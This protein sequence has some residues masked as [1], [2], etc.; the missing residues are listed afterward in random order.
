MFSTWRRG[1]AIGVLLAVVAACGGGDDDDEDVSFD[2]EES[3]TFERDDAD[4]TTTT[5]DPTE[6]ID[7]DDVA[8]DDV[9]DAVIFAT[10]DELNL[11]WED[12]FAEVA[13]GPFEPVSGGFFPYG[14]DTEIPE[15]GAPLSYEEI[16]QN[17]FYCPVNDI[18]AWDTDNLT[19]GMLEEFGAFSL[20]IV[21]AHEYGHAVQA[22]GALDPTLDTIA[23]EQQADCFA[24]SFTAFVADGGSDVLSVEVDDLD[25]AVAGFLSLR[26]APGTPTDDP[27]AHGSA[28]DRVGAF[29]DGFINGSERCAEY[30]DIYAGGGTT[31]IP[32]VFTEEDFRTG[33]NAPFDPSERGNIFDL[34]FGS[35]ETF[36]NEAMP[37]F[38][39]VEWNP[40]FP[41][42]VVA[43]SV[44]D[45]DSLPPCPGVDDLTV[46]DAAGQAF[47]CFG[48]PDDPSDDY[49]AF[50]IELAAEQYD[51][52][53][54]FA[55]SG[56]I[57]QQ[58]AFIAQ[59]LLGN[60]ESDK[61]S[62]LQADCFS[63]AWTA[64]L[65]IATL[66]DGFQPLDPEFDP[67]GIEGVSISAG[68][69]DEAVQ[70][71]LLL[72]EGADAEVEG[73]TFERVASYRDGFLNGLESCATYLDDGAPTEEE[74]VPEEV[75]GG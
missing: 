36:W 59:V 38:F 4:E 73:T 6:G 69:L 55:V 9:D 33:G 16:A 29:Q 72:G 40:L 31:A 56:V 23:G 48:D 27:S 70:S 10:L 65:T 68:D 53:G 34:T 51:S 12:E 15:C 37:G 2:R 19:N 57:A 7:L 67:N 61:P 26:D 74:G 14:P 21:M 50:D 58:Y 18:I 41:D 35:L 46:E 44:D 43:F 5:A 13:A 32:L 75:R 71:F 30:E 52:V 24:G 60:L 47:T 64:A 45:P 39:D 42:N 49:I 1:I 66:E 54:D 62:F 11:F 8:P 28:F 17:A 22:R 25:S 20:V 3:S 63:G